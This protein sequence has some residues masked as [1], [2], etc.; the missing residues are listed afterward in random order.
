MNKTGI[1]ALGLAAVLILLWVGVAGA[2]SAAN[3]AL[4]WQVLSMGGAPAN[5]GNVSLNG[6]LGQA[7]IGASS[8]GNV[9]L[10]SGFWYGVTDI[11]GGPTLDNGIYL[12][13][14]MRL[15]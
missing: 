8:G 4:D 15:E 2:G 10:S 6:T 13:L 14:I 3:V 12:P 1:S 9:N 7:I 11:S 5:G